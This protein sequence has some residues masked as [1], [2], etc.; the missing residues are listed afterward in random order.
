MGKIGTRFLQKVCESE[1]GCD[2]NLIFCYFLC[3]LT[4]LVKLIMYK[5]VKTNMDVKIKQIN[6]KMS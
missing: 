1:E 6:G 4:V 5:H 2:E 3:S